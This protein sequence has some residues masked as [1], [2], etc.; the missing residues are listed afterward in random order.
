MNQTRTLR[1]HGIARLSLYWWRPGC[2]ESD[3]YTPVTIIVEC[4]VTGVYGSDSSHPGRHSAMPTIHKQCSLL[5]SYARRY[6]A[7]SI[8]PELQARLNNYGITTFDEVSLREKLEQYTSTYTLI[9]LAEW[10][11]RRWKCH[12]RLMMG[13]RIY[14]AQSV[15]EAYALALLSVVA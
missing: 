2:D 3:P 10:P 6:M 8:P 12:Y 11:A 5:D 13:E 9:K 7:D 15:A 1:W 4:E 14:D